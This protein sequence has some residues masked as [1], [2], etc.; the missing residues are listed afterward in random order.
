MLG[1]AG[2]KG[3][4]REVLRAKDDG[5]LRG[6]TPEG[7]EIGM[8]DKETGAE[9][10][11]LGATVIEEIE[12]DEIE[13]T[14]RDPGATATV[15]TETAIGAVTE[16]EIIGVLIVILG[17]EQWKPKN[18]AKKRVRRRMEAGQHREAWK[19]LPR[20]PW[21]LVGTDM[22]VSQDR[23]RD[24]LRWFMGLQ[25][26]V[27]ELWYHALFLRRTNRGDCTQKA[28]SSTRTIGTL[29]IAEA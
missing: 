27:Q 7:G 26:Q 3:E 24:L 21:P 22:I 10:P 15:G 1:S 28:P 11:V 18:P 16:I 29:W 19:W 20:L 14:A 5:T 12:I 17:R 13:G 2:P 4:V 23:R 25:G 9:V 6:A 8:T